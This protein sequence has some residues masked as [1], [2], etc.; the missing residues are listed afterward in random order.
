MIEIKVIDDV[1]KALSLWWFTD[2]PYRKHKRNTEHK[3]NDKAN[4]QVGRPWNNS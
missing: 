2:S 3:E 1:F 4:Y